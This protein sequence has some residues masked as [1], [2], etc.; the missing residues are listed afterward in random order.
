MLAVLWRCYEAVWCIQRRPKRDDGLIAISNL[1]QHSMAANH[2]QRPALA[3]NVLGLLDFAPVIA[4][5]GY[6]L[7]LEPVLATCKY[8]WTHPEL[9]LLAANRQHGPQKRTRLLSACHHARV[10]RV[11]H[12]LAHGANPLQ[13][14]RELLKATFH[15]GTS[16]DRPLQCL[17]A[18]MDRGLNVAD[19]PECLEW[20][21]EAYRFGSCSIGERVLRCLLAARVPVNDA[22][23]QCAALVEA[24]AA[25]CTGLV[26]VLLGA[27]ANPNTVSGIYRQTALLAV[28][29][30]G[31]SRLDDA[32]A[33][34][35]LLVK[36]GASINAN[37]S[38]VLV[39][40]ISGP[41]FASWLTWVQG[42]IPMR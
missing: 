23:G 27:G 33:C 13:N 42:S 16:D 1:L 41:S 38:E 35:R 26:Q 31:F 25:I 30:Y 8:A 24:C 20:T 21:V 40:A 15:C 34:I 11:V 2:A 39:R 28:L 37:K 12:L 7:E 6:S 4:S 32:V 14:A 19:H 3:A 29:R 17:Q 10:E 22:N 9:T 18:L 5:V 36:H